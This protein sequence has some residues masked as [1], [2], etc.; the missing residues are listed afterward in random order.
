MFSERAPSGP[1]EF[2][3]EADATILWHRFLCHGRS[4][5]VCSRPRQAVFSRWHRSD[6]E[7]MTFDVPEDLWKY[8]AE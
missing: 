8:W 7:E 6:R 4:T 3:G 2:T 1:V 5:N